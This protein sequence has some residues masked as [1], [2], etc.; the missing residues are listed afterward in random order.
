MNTH[1]KK[2]VIR[3]QAIRDAAFLTGKLD[4][5]LDRAAPLPKPVAT[6]WL[7]FLEAMKDSGT[8]WFVH[9]VART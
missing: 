3:S 5:A 6:A 8:Q 1:M 2:V 9:P 7:A 4:K